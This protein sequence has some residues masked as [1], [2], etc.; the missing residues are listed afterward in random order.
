MSFRG[1]LLPISFLL[2]SKVW[3]I[4]LSISFQSFSVF[5]YS[6]W[7]QLIC[8]SASESKQTVSSCKMFLKYQYVSCFKW[9]FNTSRELESWA[10]IADSQLTPEMSVTKCD[11]TWPGL[12]LTNGQSLTNQIVH[13]LLSLLTI[14][15]LDRY[16]SYFI[17]Y[18]PFQWKPRLSRRF[19]LNRNVFYF[20]SFKY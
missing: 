18:I 12:W 13:Y 3:L 16:K 10:V 5:I 9:Q 2:I 6:C 17:F 1:V 14:C 7:N 4:L 20:Y 19:M 8:S 15:S 11:Y